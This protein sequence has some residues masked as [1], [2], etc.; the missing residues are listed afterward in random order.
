MSW[1]KIDRKK[2]YESKF[3]NVF[4]DT[5]ETHEGLV[6][7]KY[8]VIEKPDIVMVVATDENNNI[9]I[10]HEYKYAQDQ[11]L[12]TLPAGHIHHG[13]S[14]M[15]AAKREL[16]EET[17]F[18]TELFEESAEVYDYPTK[19]LHKVYI[20]RARNIEKVQIDHHETTEEL[21]YELISIDELK[22]Q[23]QNKEWKLT[24]AVT[25]L[26]ICGIIS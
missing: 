10:L 24:S 2:V 21:Q 17:G 25:A 23:I 11:V 4:E 5:V 19:D 1:K 20:V 12:N 14:P 16:L 9:L 18:H 7:D 13:E 8:T 26:A 3:V 22:K 15:E 6:I